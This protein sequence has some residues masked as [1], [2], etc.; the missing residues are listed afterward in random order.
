MGDN[1]SNNYNNQHLLILV[2][3]PGVSIAQG[4]P[5]KSHKNPRKKVLFLTILA[6]R[7]CLKSQAITFEGRQHYIRVHVFNLDN[8]LTFLE[9]T[10]N[11][12]PG[13]CTCQATSL[14]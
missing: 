14:H 11:M 8:K 2:L 1:G 9:S 10:K 3:G 7:T 13:P 5:V 12:N 6:K 4:L